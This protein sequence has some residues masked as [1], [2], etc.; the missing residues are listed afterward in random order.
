MNLVSSL[1]VIFIWIGTWETTSF[2]IDTFIKN[3]YIKRIVYFFLAI[4]SIT[5]ARKLDIDAV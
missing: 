4:F 5:L 1:L 2:F 3:V